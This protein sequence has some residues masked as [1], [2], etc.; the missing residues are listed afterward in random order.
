M[1]SKNTVEKTGECEN[2]GN[3]EIIKAWNGVWHCEIGKREQSSGGLVGIKRK[4]Y[5]SKLRQYGVKEHTCNECNLKS[6]DFRFFDVHHVNGVHMDN[7]KENL[8]LLCPNCHR[9]KTIEY[10]NKVRKT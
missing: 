6:S 10:W 8:Q 4:T 5:R 7:R 1:L 9:N 2:C 3:V